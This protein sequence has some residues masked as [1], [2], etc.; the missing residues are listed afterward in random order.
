MI[1]YIYNNTRSHYEVIISI[2]EKYDKVLSINKKNDNI[3]YLSYVTNNSFTKYIKDKYPNILLIIPEKYD[4]FINCSIY[5]K[6]LSQITN[7]D[8]HFYIAHEITENL[9]KKDNVYYLTPLCNNNKY[10][11]CDILPYQNNKIQSYKCMQAN[12]NYQRHTNLANN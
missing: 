2:I 6:N 5:E 11:Y 12:C 3:I 7:D 10:I 4:Y 8:K 1:I 9:L